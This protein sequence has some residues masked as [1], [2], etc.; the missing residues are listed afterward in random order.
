MV[1]LVLDRD[2]AA[3]ADEWRQDAFDSI[4]LAYNVVNVGNE[5]EHFVLSY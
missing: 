2:L 4:G 1:G 5:T 3:S